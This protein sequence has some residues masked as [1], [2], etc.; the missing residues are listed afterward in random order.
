MKHSHFLLIAFLLLFQPERL[1][2]EQLPV[3]FND[4][5]GQEITLQETPRRVV[6]LVPSITEILMRI[7]AADSVVGITTHDIRP[8]ETA[9]KTLVGGFLNPD[10]N[11]VAELQ[12]DVIF[13]ADLHKE[14]LARLPQK[15]KTICLAPRT[16]AEGF[17]N[18]H[19]LGKV[20]H[21]ESRAEALIAEEQRQLEVI[22]AKVA[23][24]PPEERQRVIR[25][26]GTDPL[27]VPG[28]DSFQNE[29]IR[30]AGG[31]APHF[32][33]SGKII[34][35]TLTEWQNFNPQVIYSCGRP[36]SAA[37]L[38]QPGWREV[39]AVRN[40]RIL[41]FPCELTCRLASN[42]GTFVSW[43]AASIYGEQFSRQ[44][45]YV[46]KEEVVARKPL[47]LD[48]DYIKNAEIITSNISDFRNKTLLLSF[49][50][51]MTVV[52][53]LEGQKSGITA[54]AN[55][56]F[57]PPA[58]G[59]S[60]AQG[61]DGLR[62]TSCQVLGL[63]PDATAMLFTGADMDNLAVVKKTFREM[64]VVALVTAGVEGNAMR[65]GADTGSFYEPDGRP[66]RGKPGTINILLLN[67]MQLSPQAMTR[68]I[69]SA[70]EGK[71]AAL[72]DL[73]IRSSYSGAVHAATGTGTDNMIVVEGARTAIDGTGGHTKMGELIARAVY[74]GVR[75]AIGKQNGLTEKRSIFKQL[76]ER[77]INLGEIRRNDS[78]MRSRIEHSLLDPQNA[79]FMQAALAIS[80]QYQRGLITDLSA[81]DAW[82]QAMADG[83]AGTPT[84]L[85]KISDTDVPLVIGK[86][87]AV[88]AAGDK[89]TTD[90]NSDSMKE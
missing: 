90:R 11:R 86:A 20:F 28:D 73:D 1:L 56:F 67:N 54:V 21:Q 80:D 17:A 53:T 24:I 18:I 16:I 29:Y 12:P 68:A 60:H 22:T 78:K 25:L 87:L 48:L 61:A 71:T 33:K 39:D 69:I 51:P 9:N 19:L 30:A 35:V 59:L 7:G 4:F 43:L 38:Q 13:Y 83:I 79:S 36:E 82:C 8:I 40:G 14:A 70:T 76:E 42:S 63:Q 47:V 15:A 5:S 74:D 66:S 58:W 46:Q 49:N 52:S 84:P 23:K 75:E 72:Q 44:E 27:M 41:F 6:S 2:S 26:M 81:F 45:Q 85:A 89:A 77:K 32:G 3:T 65:M 57:P 88:F 37:A 55:H 34:P 50:Q 10:L 62:Q 31:V 64:E